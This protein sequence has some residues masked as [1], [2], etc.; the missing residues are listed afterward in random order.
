MRLAVL[1]EAARFAM[2]KKLLTEHQRSFFSSV[3]ELLPIPKHKFKVEFRATHF[4]LLVQSN[5]SRMF[6]MKQSR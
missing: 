6:S 4:R 1:A 2:K 5:D 3:E